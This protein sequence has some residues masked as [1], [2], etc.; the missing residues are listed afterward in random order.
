M[1]KITR[2]VMTALSIRRKDRAY[3]IWYLYHHI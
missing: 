2:A 3:I 1:A